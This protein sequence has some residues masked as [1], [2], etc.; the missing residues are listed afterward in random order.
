MLDKDC[1]R[2]HRIRAARRSRAGGKTRRARRPGARERDEPRRVARRT[3][4]G[5]VPTFPN[6]PDGSSPEKCLRSVKASASS[7]SDSESWRAR[8]A[9]SPIR[10]GSG[11][12]CHARARSHDVGTGRSGADRF[13][14]GTRERLHLWKSDGGRVDADRGRILRRRR[15]VHSACPIPGR[16]GDRHVTVEGKARKAEGVQGSMSA[17]TPASTALPRKC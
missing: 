8:T 3:S 5:I 13:H 4:A 14:H 11:W 2:R 15:R 9:R 17:S 10:S 16:T 7:S 12:P 6:A 1:W